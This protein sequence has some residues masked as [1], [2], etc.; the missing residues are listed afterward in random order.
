MVMQ[1]GEILE[2]VI[3]RNHISIS[4]LSRKLNVSRRSIYNW[5]T[6]E[7]LSRDVIYKIGTVLNHDFSAE[8]PDLFNSSTLVNAQ[9]NGNTNIEINEIE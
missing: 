3:R 2:R 4:E 6:Q 1:K 5:F 8:F 9:I 7:R